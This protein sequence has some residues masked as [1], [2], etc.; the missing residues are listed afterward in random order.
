MRSPLASYS[1]SIIILAAA[2]LLRWLLDPVLGDA[3]PLVTLYGV[4]AVAVWLG[5]YR[6]AV[7]VAFLGYFAADYLII[8][9][10]GQM[11]TLDIGDFVGFLAYLSTCA[12]IILIGDAARRANARA[13]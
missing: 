7:I 1:L 9:P 5:G 13:D 10:R 2:L 8:V 12:F 11:G 4:V 6:P 3:L